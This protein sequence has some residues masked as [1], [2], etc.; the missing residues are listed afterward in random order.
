[1]KKKEEALKTA[2]EIEALRERMA[3]LQAEVALHETENYYWRARI[4]TQLAIAEDLRQVAYLEQVHAVD[5]DS[6]IEDSEEQSLRN[7]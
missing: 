7:S 1:M 3:C 5:V 2:L 4:A 6:E